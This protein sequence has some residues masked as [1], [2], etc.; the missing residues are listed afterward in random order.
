MAQKRWDC[1]IKV[2]ST[3]RVREFAKHMEKVTALVADMI[4]K[5]DV[6]KFLCCSHPLLEKKSPVHV[7][8]NEGEK[9]FRKVM[10]LLEGMATGSFQ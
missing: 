1:S 5:E 2:R 10:E 6:S 3:K 4:V 7:M 9:G 8:W